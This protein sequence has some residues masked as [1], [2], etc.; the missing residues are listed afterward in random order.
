M[1]NR[2]LLLNGSPRKQ[3]TSVAFATTLAA[4][5]AAA[6]C[7]AEI[8]HVYDYYDGRSALESLQDLIAGADVIGLIA[9]LYYDTLPGADVWLLEQLQGAPLAGKGFFVVGQG[10]YPFWRLCQPLIGAGRCFAE[11]TGMRW[12]G[13][14]GYG[15]GVLIDGRPL[16]QY[17]RLGRRIIEALRLALADVLQGRPI[18]PKPQELLT[19]SIPRILFRP[20]A[21]AL[22]FRIWST[23]R[24][25]GVKD[26]ARK[27]YLE[28]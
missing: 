14:L 4:Q 7:T 24:R 21:A 18:G 23:A 3:G 10:A 25:L 13:G 11:A 1:V 5:A 27:V 2:L 28:Q 22:N 15:G 8:R 26:F 17:G 9:P 12:L 20:L 19:I 6:G 16:D